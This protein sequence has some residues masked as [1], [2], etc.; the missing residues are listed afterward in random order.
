MA[1]AKLL[2]ALIAP[3]SEGVGDSGGTLGGERHRSS[4]S[5]FEE[6]GGRVPGHAEAGL[7]RGDGRTK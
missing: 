2:A 4:R 6:S 7:S 3:V 5:E 1:Q